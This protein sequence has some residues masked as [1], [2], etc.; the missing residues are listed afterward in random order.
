MTDAGAYTVSAMNAC[1]EM[2]TEVSVNVIVR[3]LPTILRQPRDSSAIEGTVASLRV[4][5]GGT[6][7]RYQWRKNGV[8]RV[9]DTSSVLTIPIAS[10]S[11]S[12][13][14]DCVVSNTCQTIIS[15]KGMLSITKAPSGP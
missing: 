10:L 4:I 13:S 5:A 11:D 9:G 6:D 14:Y 1:N 7:I 3:E 8:N 12:G 2:S 15:A